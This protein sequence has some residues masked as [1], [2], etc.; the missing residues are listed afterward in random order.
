MKTKL[1]SAQALVI[2]I[3]F[4]AVV[5]I[6]AAS[7]FG[8]V[9]DFI[10][11]GGRSYL[12][13]E[14]THIA[15]AG[16]DYTLWQ[17]NETGGS[18]SGIADT[19]V[20]NTGT[21]TT[22]VADAGTNL[23]KI[24]STS[25]IPNSTN[26]RAKRTAKVDVLVSTDRIAFKY[27]VQVGSE[28]VD[29]ANS[30]TIN[31]TVYTNGNINGSG[32]SQINGEAYAH[33]S[34]S[35]PD[36]LV[37]CP[38]PQCKH[39]NAPEEDLPTLNLT[40]A[41]NAAEAGEINN[42]CPCEI[43]NEIKTIGP[44]KYIGNLTITNNSI[45]TINGPI[46]VTGDLAVTQGGTKVNLNESF[47]SVGTYFIVDGTVSVS[48][49][50]NFNPTGANPKGYIMVVTT[51]TSNSA[52]SIA[53]SGANAIFYALLGGADLSQSAQ[54]NA[55]VANKL[56]MQNSATLNYDTGL[57]SSQFSSGPGGSWQIRKGSYKYSSS[58]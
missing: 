50:G 25:Y 52:M 36:P 45:V 21:F 32:T 28:G 39:P 29:M 55:L 54:V 5:M 2:S 35:S 26:P 22:S 46:W 20:G 49:G 34:I 56:N 47:G 38:L 15:D 16:I 9:A 1:K 37:S 41:K 53:N 40:D 11:F 48:Q 4:L 10:R 7:L 8:K 12:N 24:T 17:L 44:Q 23:K 6:L 18:F 58:P 27:A 14:A 3:I 43:N 19:Q 42:T 57:A 13:E 30:S 51:S 31:G 33:G